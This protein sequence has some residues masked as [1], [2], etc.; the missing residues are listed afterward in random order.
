MKNWKTMWYYV[1]ATGKRY[2][3]GR[4]TRDMLEARVTLD[5]ARR[6]YPGEEWNIVAYAA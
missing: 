4:A 5:N 2:S 3:F 6:M 1:A